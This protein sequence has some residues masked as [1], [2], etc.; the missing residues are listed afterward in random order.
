M[1]KLTPLIIALMLAL[2]LI[3]GCT[4]E[5]PATPPTSTGVNNGIQTTE[6]KDPEPIST[7]LETSDTISSETET[8]V[9]TEAPVAA[10]GHV[11]VEPNVLPEKW[12]LEQ[13]AQFPKENNFYFVSNVLH[14]YS[15]ADDDTDLLSPVSPSGADIVS[16]PST[17]AELVVPG[18]YSVRAYADGINT[19]GLYTDDG[20]ELIPCEAAIITP[21]LFQWTDE[22]E[23]YTRFL[24][25]IYGTE[26]TENE[27]E[28]F[29]YATTKMFAIAP[30]DG[31]TFYKGYARIYDLETR[32]FVPDLTITN[33]DSS[34][35][36]PGGSIFK[37]EDEKHKTYVYN[38]DGKIVYETEASVE[39]GNGYF[40]VEYKNVY[41]E[42]GELLFKSDNYLNVVKGSGLFL[43]DGDTVRDM[44]GNKM[45]DIPEDIYI[46]CESGGLFA[47]SNSNSKSC[48]LY[49]VSGNAV[50]SA[51][52]DSYPSYKGNGI[53]EFY[54]SGAEHMTY[55]LLNG[56]TV[57]SLD[58]SAYNLVL[59]SSDSKQL[60][61]WNTPDKIVGIT[62]SVST[63]PIDTLMVERIESVDHL[64]DCFTGEELVSAQ[65]ITVTKDGYVYAAQD[66]VMT[67]YKL[68]AN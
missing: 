45:F 25:V 42:N 66:D 58:K 40:V 43:K 34:A 7:A 24:Y 37:Y 64:I 29:F 5:T 63:T 35:A 54:V 4:A 19:T 57:T 44:Y 47:V 53:W 18:V 27:N 60:A 14:R 50:Y 28:A 20:T 55:Y 26:Q 17:G 13:C 16:F 10:K 31:D 56:K 51:E 2:S 15:K 38:T 46:S 3:A 36:R 8:P 33:S 23:K 59:K 52:L 68:N 6:A 30:Q 62:G 65:N 9:E 32:K 11:E 1:K 21:L 39:M 67:V 49:D 61:P 12:T 41:D 48:A 22:A